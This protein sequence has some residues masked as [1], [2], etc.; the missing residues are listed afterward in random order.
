MAKSKP[1]FE[2]GTNFAYSNTN[3]IL[4]GG[5]VETLTGQSMES[6]L[7]E[8]FFQSDQCSHS[9]WLWTGVNFAR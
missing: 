7:Q 1:D 8:R 6:L 2:P 9:G 3:F 4:L 5:I